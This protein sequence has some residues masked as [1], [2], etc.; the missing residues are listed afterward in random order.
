MGSSIKSWVGVIFAI[1]GVVAFGWVSA[2]A[3]RLR[4]GI[5]DGGK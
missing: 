4:A 1:A 2:V 5:Y 3:A